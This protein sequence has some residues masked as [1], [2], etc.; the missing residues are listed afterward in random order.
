MPTLPNKTTLNFAGGHI[1]G[2][3]CDNCAQTYYYLQNN[4]SV[5]TKFFRSL[6]MGAVKRP[7][8][9]TACTHMTCLNCYLVLIAYG[10]DEDE[11]RFIQGCPND[12]VEFFIDRSFVHYRSGSN[13]MGHSADYHTMKTKALNDFVNARLAIVAQ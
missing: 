9:C 12:D 4:P 8:G 10:F 13:W 5:K 6:Y 7:M 1:N 11:I 3:A 2:F